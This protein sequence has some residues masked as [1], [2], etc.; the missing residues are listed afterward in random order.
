ML[1]H[2]LTD[3]AVLQKWLKAPNYHPRSAWGGKRNA[4]AF[5]LSDKL[6]WG[7]SECGG[8][9]ERRRRV[10]GQRSGT[11]MPL[12]GREEVHVTMKAFL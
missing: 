2:V 7:R 4:A 3:K 8:F 10:A 12:S 6:E 9:V 5:W 11:K 1:K